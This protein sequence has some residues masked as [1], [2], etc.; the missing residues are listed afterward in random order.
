MS[1]FIGLNFQDQEG[2]QGG[3]RNRIWD[4]KN[5]LALGYPSGWRIEKKNEK[6]WVRGGSEAFPLSASALAEGLVLDLTR[7]ESNP[8]TLTIRPQNTLPA[9]FTQGAT[10]DIENSEQ[11]IRA[12][13]CRG[14]WGVSSEV[15]GDI[16][17]AS[18]SGVELF[19]IERRE[20]GFVLAPY[21]DGL[22]LETN[23]KKIPV[24]RL[25]PIWLECSEL[26]QCTLYGAES[27]SSWK[28][29]HVVAEAGAFTLKMGAIDPEENRERI[30]FRRSLVSAAAVIM[31][32]VGVAVFWP[33][34]FQKELAQKLETTAEN[35]SKLVPVRLGAYVNLKSTTVSQASRSAQVEIFRSQGF[36]HSLSQLM[37]GGMTKLLAESPE[38]G[39]AGERLNEQTSGAVHDSDRSTSSIIGLANGGE[40]AKVAAI[41]GGFGKGVGY[42]KGDHANVSG[43][44]HSYVAMDNSKS[45]VEEGLTRDEVG[46]VI[47]QHISEVRYCYESSM[48]RLPQ[49][50]GKLL[51]GF[52]IGSSGVVRT[53]EVKSSTLPDAK[54]DD[55]ILRRLIGWKFPSTKGGVDVAVSYPFI[56][57]TLGG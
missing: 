7:G 52:T 39:R 33:G 15:L 28:F 10:A 42:G 13:F 22:L 30:F 19:S 35:F 55:C 57:K 32:I 16:F 49:V 54:L 5:D 21:I 20:V 8:V 48:L 50:E 26:L 25:V 4:G 17:V 1:Y 44:G 24:A 14:K 2:G 43:Q 3:F 40:G 38:T 34:L 51:M 46:E 45:T 41:G 36:N 11:G 47:H 18:E 6:F 12:N 23:G 53:A 27:K 56:F 29:N 9:A 37:Q 31:S